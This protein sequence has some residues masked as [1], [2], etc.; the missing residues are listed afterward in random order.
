MKS[1]SV[2]ERLHGTNTVA[3]AQHHSNRESSAKTQSS[4]KFPVEIS[5]KK[6]KSGSL[7]QSSVFDRL[8]TKDTVSHSAR[9]YIPV[10]QRE[11]PTTSGPT[12]KRRS[13]GVA[14]SNKKNNYRQDQSSVFERLCSSDTVS[15]SAKIRDP[16]LTGSVLAHTSTLRHS[17]F[18]P[19][20]ADRNKNRL[21]S[22]TEIGQANLMSK[23]ENKV[24]TP[25]ASA[26]LKASPQIG[27]TAPTV[28][29]QRRVRKLQ[30][31]HSSIKLLCSSR[32]SPND[33]Y[34]TLSPSAL[35]L[36]ATLIS[37]E[38]GKLTAREVAHSIIEALF[39]RDFMPR[40]H[41]DIDSATV[42]LRSNEGDT[43][44]GEDGEAFDVEKNA[45]WDWKDIYSVASAKGIVR[46]VTGKT[47]IRVENYSYY[48]AG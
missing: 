38:S 37:Y 31:S 8:Y 33:G 27:Q 11:M 22:R 4:R 15:H 24:S 48:V 23:K 26:V 14:K 5:P 28:C 19:V 12:F 16:V 40:K 39:K 21:K 25:T 6:E 2:F 30:T 17:R 29:E 10:R 45:T 34:T 43:T 3:S 41:W 42:A 18:D 13:P 32:Y 35:G 20:R 46:F 47:E 1:S 7:K 9:K 36:G 44:S